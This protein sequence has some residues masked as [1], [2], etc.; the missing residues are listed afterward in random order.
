MLLTCLKVVSRLWFRHMYVGV[1]TVKDGCL[2]IIL[3]ASYCMF[4]FFQGLISGSSLCFHLS[5]VLFGVDISGTRVGVVV[6]FSG[7]ALG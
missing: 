1:L 2:G 3:L 4:L 7:L 5:L 6:G